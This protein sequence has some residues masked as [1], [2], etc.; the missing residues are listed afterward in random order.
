MREER[1][2]KTYF[3]YSSLD[4]STASKNSLIPSPVTLDT[5]TAYNRQVV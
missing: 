4:A 2:R 3:S 5:P 1:K